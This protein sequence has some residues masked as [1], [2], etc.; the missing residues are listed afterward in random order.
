MTPR[1]PTNN[2]YR[3]R[4]RRSPVTVILL[5][6]AAGG[7]GYVLFGGKD[8]QS[9]ITA[10]AIPVAQAPVGVS[11]AEAPPP[12]QSPA[13]R[14]R[15]SS[16][17]ENGKGADK[18]RD[19]TVVAERK[20]TTEEQEVRETERKGKTLALK[21]SDFIVLPTRAITTDSYTAP[22]KSSAPAPGSS[23]SATATRDGATSKTASDRSAAKQPTADTGES[24]K[25]GP[26]NRSSEEVSSGP[27]ESQPVADLPP[28]PHGLTP[29]VRPPDV[30]L[31]FYDA[32]ASRRVVLPQEVH[33]PL[34]AVAKSGVPVK[35]P[36]PG[37]ATRT[38]VGSA[39]AVGATA[40]TGK[41][42]NEVPRQVDDSQAKK[43]TGQPGNGTST[44]DSG[45]YMVQLAVFSTPERA[46]QMVSQLQRKGRVVHM[47]QSEGAAG[48][49]YRVRSGPYPSL[50]DAKQAM[51]G[52]P[53]EG[54][55][56]VIIKPTTR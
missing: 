43:G 41:G 25:A 7:G 1:Y 15:P 8:S 39:P 37:T 53:T 36:F 56:P 54:Q 45:S 20:A 24:D 35:P 12:Q 22:P 44:G 28:L 23:A 55:A 50:A 19:T 49:I 32:L 38:V 14:Q 6:L 11:G 10:L 9:P 16:E 29:K 31:T 48:P 34:A 2:R 13:A 18:N 26:D 46:N 47:V 4:T 42:I 3:R 40:Q 27:S 30:Q 21:V 5:G 17:S 51:D 52:L 33:D